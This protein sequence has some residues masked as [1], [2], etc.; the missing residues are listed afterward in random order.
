MCC[1]VI[2]GVLVMELEVLV[3]D[4]LIV[5]LDFKGCKEMMEMFSCLYK[6]YNMIIVLVIYLMDDVV[7]YVD[8][9]IV[10]EKG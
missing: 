2:V 7:N 3:L 4:E 9:V 6:E 8:Y 5:G 1:V 10:L